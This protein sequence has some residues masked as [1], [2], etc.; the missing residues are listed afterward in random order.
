[1]TENDI[2]ADDTG[3]K[4]GSS[5]RSLLQASTSIL[6]GTVITN[7]LGS[8]DGRSASSRQ[9]LSRSRRPP[10]RP[11]TSNSARFIDPHESRLI[12]RGSLYFP[13]TTGNGTSRA[14]RS[15]QRIRRKR[16]RRWM[17]GIAWDFPTVTTSHI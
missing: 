5:R 11:S 16:R 13:A 7:A 10:S 8:L 14:K 17:T 2:T 3:K 4:N 6:T 1:M 12:L 15:T 9:S